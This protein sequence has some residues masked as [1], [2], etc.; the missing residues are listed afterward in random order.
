MIGAT[1]GTQPAPAP[2]DSPRFP[3]RCLRTPASAGRCADGVQQRGAD[4]SVHAVSAVSLLPPARQV[5]RA[6]C[7]L[8]AATGR[9]WAAGALR[10][11]SWVPLSPLP[12]APLPTPPTP[13]P[14]HPAPHPQGGGER[15]CAREVFR[16]RVR[17]P[18]PAACVPA[19][20]DQRLPRRLVLTALPAGP[21]RRAAQGAQGAGH[22][23]CGAGS[24]AVPCTGGR[25]FVGPLPAHPFLLTP[26]VLS[27]P[28]RSAP[29]RSTR[30]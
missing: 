29:P 6:L 30:G 27:C 1:A 7:A 22:V 5:R 24:S 19:V 12:T 18:H 2:A 13:H 20:E 14:T 21:P 15:R 11:S 3:A 28:A 25:A 10:H 17:P 16:A 4:R 26:A 8:C 23:A 9:A